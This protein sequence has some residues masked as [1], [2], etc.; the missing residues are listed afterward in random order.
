MPGTIRQ[1]SALGQSQLA[2]WEKIADDW[3]LLPRWRDERPSRSK[4][5]AAI[6]QL[7]LACSLCEI[8]V[9]ASSEQS[10]TPAVLKAATVAHIRQFH[11]EL[12]PDA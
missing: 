11:R 5:E 1:I 3:I 4:W 9:Y 12:D 2:E 8:S 7:H 10:I 6:P